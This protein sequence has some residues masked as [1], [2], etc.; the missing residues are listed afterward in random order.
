[1]SGRP[2]RIRSL[3]APRAGYSADEYEDAF[4]YSAPEADDRYRGS[5]GLPPAADTTRRRWRP[6]ETLRPFADAVGARS[7][8]AEA[9]LPLHAAVADGATE[10]AFSGRWSRTLVQG[11]VERPALHELVAGARRTWSPPQDDRWYVQAKTAQGAHAAFLGMVLDREAWRAEA[12]GDCCLFHLRDE[13]VLL[14]WPLSDAEDFTHTPPLVSSR[15][16]DE[17]PAILSRTG[18]WA[19]GDTF[20]LATDALAAWLI[21]TSPHRVLA[22]EQ[23]DR[24]IRRARSERMR[25]DDVTALIITTG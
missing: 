3:W 15:V 17:M 4:A 23:G 21:A 10:A 11:Y 1:M 2:V 7:R 9:A 12:V 13:D 25:N 6:A 19:A 5:D 20:I 16:S 22:D 14:S 8:S 18:T 24:L